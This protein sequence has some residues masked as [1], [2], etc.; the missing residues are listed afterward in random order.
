MYQLTVKHYPLSNALQ[1]MPELDAVLAPLS[2]AMESSIAVAFIE[3]ELAGAQ[4]SQPIDEF[5]LTI[6][7]AW[8]DSDFVELGVEEALLNAISERAFSEQAQS[9]AIS[10]N[11]DQSELL[12]L[13]IKQG[14]LVTDLNA[15]NDA[16]K[17]NQIQLSKVI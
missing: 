11:D 5:Q 4:I 7:P 2:P 1:Q 6:K 17:G 13:L 10:T 9:L 8:V 14:F 3:G 12:S 15:R 16:S